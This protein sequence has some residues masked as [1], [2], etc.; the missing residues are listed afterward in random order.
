MNT[1]RRT[2]LKTLVVGGASMVGGTVAVAVDEERSS[3]DPRVQTPGWVVS[4]ATVSSPREVLATTLVSDENT[5]YACSI[6]SSCVGVQIRD[7]TKEYS[8]IIIQNV[9]SGSARVVSRSRS[10]LVETTWLDEEGVVVTASRVLT[11]A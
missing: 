9:T 3:S 2:I 10:N 4:F 7:L 1:T 6:G 5:I 11:P 8:E